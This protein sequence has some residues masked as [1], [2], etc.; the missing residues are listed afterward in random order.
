MAVDIVKK[1]I[2]LVDD[3]NLI[4]VTIKEIL[5]MEGY[6]VD[7]ASTFDEGINIIK[8]K[9]KLFNLIILDIHLPDNNG[10]CFID[11][12]RNSDELKA[13]KNIPIMILS[14]DSTVATVKKAIEKGANDYLN[15][16]F[17]TYELLKRI[18]KLLN[19]NKEGNYDRLIEI[20]QEEIERA[21][22]GNYSLS[23]IILSK[24]SQDNLKIKNIVEDIS[25]I[26]RK[27]DTLLELG[28]SAFCI[29][30]PFTKEEGARVVLEKIKDKLFGRWYIGI[31]EYPKEAKSAEELCKKAKEKIT[32]EI[33][34]ND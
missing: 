22:R 6:S 12:L 27:I 24:E 10:L 33:T 23:L 21:N 4:Q 26:L 34:Q 8:N 19:E 13:Y 11:L 31:S 25:K 1:N 32:K 9:G 14:S 20:L 17:S 29:V 5:E 28:P 7:T 18:K 2:L 3:S 16:P 15:K 30:L